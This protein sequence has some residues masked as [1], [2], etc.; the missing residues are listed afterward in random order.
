MTRMDGH[1]RLSC[2][3]RGSIN[4]D[5]FFH[6]PSIVRPGQTLSSTRYERRAGGKGAN[7][8]VAIARAGQYVFFVGAVGNDGRWLLDELERF[9]VCADNAVVINEEQ[10][11]RAIIQ[12]TPEGENS[13][14]LHRGANYR[15]SPAVLPPYQDR[16][17]YTHLLLQN[18]IPFD[19]TL[20]YLNHSSTRSHPSN[21]TT[22]F[23][24]S[25]M[26]TPDEIVQFPWEKLD[27]LIV[28]EGEALDLLQGMESSSTSRESQMTRD[29]NGQQP[30]ETDVVARA[31]KVLHTLHDH[32]RS[33]RKLNVICT[34][35]ANGV[36]ALVPHFT[37][38]NNDELVYVPAAKI[39]PAE[40][41]D[42][43]GAGDCFTGYFVSGL[44]DLQ[45]SKG[46]DAATTK[47]EKEDVAGILERCVH[48]AGLC[49][50]RP[51]AMGSIPSRDE[52]SAAMGL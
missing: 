21:T 6:V 34:L 28:N 35:G 9:N 30:A 14:I 18:E 32:P 29:T 52:V 33:S 20:D 39:D 19:V 37:Q 11:G 13:I 15:I 40:V 43:T 27:W 7:Q 4:I 23:N 46:V 5:E 25:P 1:S 8:A 42:T 45:H 47:L 36:L 3:V 17:E 48:A 44:M 38:N 50:R 51:G 12:L 26:P 49:V 31:S 41:C 2:L 16:L 22:F 10:T 24:P